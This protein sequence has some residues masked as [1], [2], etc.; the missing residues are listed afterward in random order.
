MKLNIKM[1][2]QNPQCPH[3]LQCVCWGLFSCHTQLRLLRRAKRMVFVIQFILGFQHCRCLTAVVPGDSQGV[4]GYEFITWCLEL[5]RNSSQ[6][7]RWRRR[8]GYCMEEP[9]VGGQRRNRGYGDAKW[10]AYSARALTARAA[11][12][13]FIFSDCWAA[14]NLWAKCVGFRWDLRCVFA[15]WICIWGQ[16]PYA[17]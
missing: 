12:L 15:G 6:R 16:V 5:Y 10:L 8:K 2:K 9:G 13:G 17:K 3:C 14:S 4:W 7:S 1:Q 11:V